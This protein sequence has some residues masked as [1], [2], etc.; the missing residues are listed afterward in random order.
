MRCAIYTRKSIEERQDA[1][2]GSL[3]N[4]R[5]YC[6][7]YIASQAGT[8]WRE[9]P[10]GYDDN[11]YSGGSLKRPALERLR[12]DIAIGV[13]DIVVVYKIDRLSRSLRDFVNLVAEFERSSVT[14]VSVT[15]SFNTG[16][17]MGRLT[18]NVLLSFAQFE[19]E[20]T[21]ERLRDWFAGARARGMWM[22]GRPPYGY[23]AS[24]KILVIDEPEAACVR[25][26]FARYPK[27]GSARLLADELNAR[28]WLNNMGRPWSKRTVTE[29]LQNPVYLGHLRHNG[30]S[31][32]GIHPPLIAMAAWRKVQATI[33]SSARRRAAL[34]RPPEPAALKGLIADANGRPMIHVAVPRKGKVYRYYVPSIR[35]YGAGTCSLNRFRAEPLE[36]AVLDLVDRLAGAPQV[37]KDAAAAA[38]MVRRLVSAVTVHPHHMT[39]TLIGGA[40]VDAPHA[41]QMQITRRPR[42][43]PSWFAEAMKMVDAG[44]SPWSVAVE[45]RIPI[46]SFY[47]IMHRWRNKT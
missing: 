15:Q 32:P 31:M 40:T 42:Q 24:S 11:G 26:A 4:Q 39:V 5:A 20:L 33:A 38:G 25:H 13:V 44:K 12:A 19:R 14:F 41:G 43:P 6:S 28:G 30:S 16:N 8:G 47:R 21:G 35:R 23:R 29:M 2:Y 9:L 7:A 17:S 34:L 45:M 10:T 3:E 37:Y 36:R 22:H 46:G 18:L 27:L 1:E